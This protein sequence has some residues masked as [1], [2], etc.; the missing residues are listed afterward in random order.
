MPEGTGYVAGAG[1][2]H[3][4]SLVP[5]P[6]CQ[7]WDVEALLRGSTLGTSHPPGSLPCQG[8]V[9]PLV[10]RSIRASGAGRSQ[11]LMLQETRGR[12]SLWRNAFH[13]CYPPGPGLLGLGD[14]VGL[15]LL[16]CSAAVGE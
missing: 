12:T 15:T 3:C 13:P 4:V 16:Q 9:L 11:V 6:V 8:T 7:G 5:G 2:W 10:P 1:C 14:S